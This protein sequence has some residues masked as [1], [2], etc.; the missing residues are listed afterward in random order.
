MGCTHPSD[1]QEFCGRKIKQKDPSILK[2]FQEVHRTRRRCLTRCFKFEKI[3]DELLEI[4]IWRLMPGLHYS[5][6]HS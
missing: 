5:I 3:K 2:A 1:G 4:E 6:G